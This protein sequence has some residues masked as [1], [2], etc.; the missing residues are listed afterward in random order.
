[1][2]EEEIIEYICDKD[3]DARV[4]Y[5]L[6]LNGYIPSEKVC[7]YIILYELEKYENLV[8][9]YYLGRTY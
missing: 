1:M 3:N 4:I 2:S 5:E 6:T 7:Y 8:C 9:E